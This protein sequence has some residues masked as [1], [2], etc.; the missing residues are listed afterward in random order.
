MGKARDATTEYF[1]CVIALDAE[2][3]ERLFAS[4]GVLSVFGGEGRPEGTLKRGRSEIR[5]YY[6]G[7]SMR[8]GHH[9]HPQEPIEEGNRCVVEVV[10]ELPD[11]TCTRV[12][13][14][15]TVNEE[16]EVTSLRVYKGLLLEEDVPSARSQ[17]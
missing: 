17:T 13:D 7:S 3:M 14:V 6:E 8:L 11:G 9:P 12:A 5:N 1:R 15:F 2:G 10:V 4:D 16:G